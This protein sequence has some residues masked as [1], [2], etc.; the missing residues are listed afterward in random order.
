MTAR[1]ARFTLGAVVPLQ[2]ID[3]S[4]DPIAQLMHVINPAAIPGLGDAIVHELGFL[5]PFHATEECD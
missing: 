4:S 5:Y 3:F 1:R 2:N